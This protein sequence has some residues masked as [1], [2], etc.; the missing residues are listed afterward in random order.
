METVTI[1]F[2][3]PNKFKLFAFAIM[4]GLGIPYSHVYVK[5][6]SSKFDRFLIY[7]ASHTTVNFCSVPIFEKNN[8]VVKEFPVQMTPDQFVSMLKFAID[9][10][11]KP[12]GFKNILGLTYVR[13]MELLGK[14]VKSPFSDN[15]RTYVCCE[16]VG[17]ILNNF[18]EKDLKLDL[19]NITPKDIYIHMER[20][21]G[22]ITNP[23]V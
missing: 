1:G 22:K 18:I 23:P 20:Q 14:K 4:K 3:K 13:I 7:Q 11:G 8:A 15:D 16:L 21:Y 6:Y 2:S 12:Y 17:A 19:N 10:C 5:F 9:N